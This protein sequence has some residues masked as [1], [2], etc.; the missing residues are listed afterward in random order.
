[1]K[2]PRTIFLFSIISLTLFITATG[3]YPGVHTIQAQTQQRR[4]AVIMFNF[5]SNPVQPYTVSQVKDVLFY[6][7]RAVDKYYREVSFGKM[8]LTGFSQPDGDVFGWYTI[9]SDAVD[10]DTSGW[11]NEAKVL[12]ANDGFIASNYDHVITIGEPYPGSCGAT[13]IT[14]AFGRD[15]RIWGTVLSES[16]VTHELGHCLGLAHANAYKCLDMNGNPVSILPNT[17]NCLN[18][19]YGDQFDVMG[20]AGQMAQFN[21]YHKLEWLEPQNLLTITSSSQ[22]GDY[23]IKPIETPSAGLQILRIVRTPGQYYYLEFRQNTGFDQP[24]GSTTSITNGVSVRLAGTNPGGNSWLL[25]M[26][27][28]DF[29][30][31]GAALEAGQTLL[32]ATFGITLTTLSVCRVT[33]A[34]AATSGAGA[35]VRVSLNPAAC[36]PTKPSIW[37]TSTT[38]NGNAGQS[39]TYTV[40][41]TNNNIVAC[42][43]STYNVTSKL[44]TKWKQSPVSFQENIQSG[45]TIIRTI[46]V[47]SPTNARSNEYIIPQKITDVTNSKLTASYPAVYMVN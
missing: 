34:C 38:Q 10:C 29:G 19:E 45:Q 35:W 2:H 25:S 22:A 32:D 42:P 15:I 31:R 18:E 33:D 20:M 16:I 43:A 47:T 3:T 9:P 44:P 12:A 21:G 37:V 8:M 24:L 39:L 4:V 40:Q 28:P 17:S 13:R 6:S 46:T 27:P 30:V 11:I 5:P 36:M 14:G 23:F 26:N 41:L 1:M 7:S